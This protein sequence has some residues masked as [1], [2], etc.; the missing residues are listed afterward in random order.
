MFS[1]DQPI[2]NSDQDL[3]Y[4]QPFASSLGDAILNY[5]ETDSLVIG[6]FGAWGSGKTSI[7][8]MALEKIQTISDG[9]KKSRRPI[10]IR[11]N[12]WNFSDQN[13]L[14][15]Q[16]FKQLSSA[17]KRKDHTSSL[18][19]L[20]EKVQAYGNL[21]EP[22][23][24]I[25]IVGNTVSSVAKI[26]KE[27]GGATKNAAISIAS[28]LESKK[29]ELNELLS[30]QKR[31]IIV[32]VDDIDRLNS[33]EIRQMFQ[34]V[35]SL[36]DFKNTIYVLAFDKTVVINALAKVQEG[37]G[38][39]YLEKVVQVPFE[40]P[41]IS[42]EEVHKLLF[43]QLDK[44]IKDI[45]EN[46][47]D[48]NYWGNV[49]HG[50][51]KYFFSNI[52]DVTRYINT[53]RFGFQIVKEEVNPI[54]FIA[55]TA[56][57]IFA[58]ELYY[59]VRDNKDL[60]SGVFES[61]HF[62]NDGEKN[63]QKSRCDEII[64]RVSYFNKDVLQKLL[65]LM[66]P[67]LEALYEYM[68][69]GHDSLSK[70]R[71]DCR[72]ASPDRF[73]IYFRLQIP[74]GEISQTEIEKIISLASDR[75]E[76]TEALQSLNKSGNINRFLEL[77]EDFTDDTI[78]EDHIDNVVCTL[79]DIGDSLPEGES[80]F[81]SIDNPM[82]I[83]RIC[84]QLGQRFK[85]QNRRFQL[86]KNAIELS[87]QSLHT[88]VLEVSIQDQQHGRFST[89]DKP[90]PED[91][92]TVN[93]KQLDILEKL[94]LSKIEIWAKNGRLATHP[95]LPYIL[96]RWKEWGKID[97][98]ISFVDSIIATDNGL[99]TFIS[100]FLYKST[101]YSGSDYVGKHHWRIPTD[102]IR[103][104][105]EL[106][107]IENRVREILKAKKNENITENQIFAMQVLVETIDGKIKELD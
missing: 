60:F 103:E 48:Q 73:E 7:L 91:Q 39:E 95:K 58:P 25:P 19:H 29:S 44:L 70:W 43:H 62:S 102:S 34:L 42:K 9:L 57:Q 97:D 75:E 59:G 4:R 33:I 99:V 27:L 32:I 56:L 6:L 49:W 65:A 47:W 84:F 61:T 21:F 12:P 72:I 105:I 83:M 63:K 98:V 15:S 82:R 54:D 46:K 3:L 55:V 22:L 92:F 106:S 26:V 69:Y 101:S 13:Q 51:L 78:Q 67:K 18:Q 1:P 23:G 100:S 28:D 35:K 88:I 5:I 52:R 107:K 38:S 104:F 66:F 96:Y 17:L 8:N 53:L 68:R 31:K 86:F 10:I 94:A 30:K 76:F 41:S 85:D 77:F 81:L 71:K 93:E 2:Q 20:G 74:Q 11:F 24:F 40:V 90:K 79:M 87:S 16:F 37:A 45:P 80:G 14:I 50:G 36:G 64:N 89:K